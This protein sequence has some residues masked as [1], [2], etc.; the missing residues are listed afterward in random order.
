[1]SDLACSEQVSFFTNNTF[2]IT[3]CPKKSENNSVIRNIFASQYQPGYSHNPVV[4]RK[5]PP[6]LSL[7]SMFSQRLHEHIHVGLSGFVSE[8][9]KFRDDKMKQL[10]IIFSKS[11]AID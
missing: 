7:Y 6:R 4:T 2:L 5:L 8:H 1:M 3:G 10:N 9:W 11:N